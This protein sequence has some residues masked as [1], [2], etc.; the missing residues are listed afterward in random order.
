MKQTT[1]INPRLVKL[2]P[3]IFFTL[4]PVL[5]LSF[6]LSSELLSNTSAERVNVT[7]EDLASYIDIDASDVDLLVGTTPEGHFNSTPETVTV[8]TSSG[9]GYQLYL[10]MGDSATTSNLYLGGDTTKNSLKA[11]AVVSGEP[12]LNSWGFSLDNNAW[13]P[14]PLKNSEARIKTSARQAFPTSGAGDTTTIYYGAKANT[15]MPGGTYTGEVRYTAVADVTAENTG[16]ATAKVTNVTDGG[17]HASINGGDSVVITTSL[18]TNVS[19]IGEVTLTIGGKTC[20]DPITSSTSSGTLVVTCDNLPTFA[21]GGKP[22]AIVSIPKFSKTYTTTVDYSDLWAITNMQD[23]TPTVCANTATPKAKDTEGNII[24]TT[25]TSRIA[26]TT[27]AEAVPQSTAVDTRDSK[28]YVIR[29]LA[30]G[31]C[32]MAQNLALGNAGYQ[33]TLTSADSDVVNDYTLP[34]GQTSFTST[35]GPNNQTN[36]QTSHVAIDDTY[37]SGGSGTPTSTPT[38]NLTDAVGYRYNWYTATAGTGLYNSTSA[39]HSICA[40]GWTLPGLDGTARPSYKTLINTTY[41][42]TTPND[43]LQAPMSMVYGGFY[44]NYSYA[45][46]VGQTGGLLTNVA[47]TSG[48][49]YFLHYSVNSSDYGLVYVKGYTSWGGAVYT[50]VGRNMRCLAR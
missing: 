29:K 38:G 19:N 36:A 20:Q 5:L 9:T 50:F 2:L 26:Y 32:W 1:N 41:G 7:L 39:D 49:V 12:E 13:Q 14:V 4:I 16:Q 6:F 18:Y 43:L 17:P 46:H 22:T 28:Q 25:T 48:R 30:D 33:M 40:K 21:S 47:G 31:N 35:W 45:D 42:I 8:H 24:G 3:R 37:L 11:T 23:M 27:E 15:S 10:A 34:I 44:G